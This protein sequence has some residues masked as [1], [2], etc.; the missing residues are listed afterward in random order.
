MTFERI[1]FEE[2]K[3]IIQDILGSQ[4]HAD[5]DLTPDGIFFLT[6][7]MNYVFERTVIPN[8]NSFETGTQDFSAKEFMALTQINLNTDEPVIVIFDECFREQ[9]A[10]KTPGSDFIFFAEHTY[11]GHYKMDF[12]QALDF[13]F[14]QP[15]QNLISMIHHEGVI[16]ENCNHPTYEK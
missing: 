3:S 13:I 8:W 1:T 11:P 15:S 2:T 14:I 9:K 4:S 16:L 6:Q 12:V 7:E 10:F 5:F